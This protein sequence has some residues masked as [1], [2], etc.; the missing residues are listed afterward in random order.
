MKDQVNNAEFRDNAVS[1][2][3]AADPTA[4]DS[5]SAES[6]SY[7]EQEDGREDEEGLYE[8]PSTPSLCRLE[9]VINGCT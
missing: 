2:G 7:S 3:T 5:S 8:P 4:F 6:I 9:S 1:M